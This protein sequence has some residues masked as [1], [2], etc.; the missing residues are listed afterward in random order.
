M[1]KVEC[2]IEVKSA[3]DKLW[4]GIKDS[5]IIFPKIFPKRLAGIEIVEGDGISTGSVRLLKYVEGTPL[6]THAKEKIELFDDENK[7]MEYSLIEG[8]L[9]MLYKSLKVCLQVVPKG[10]GSLVK[11]CM[12][13]EKASDAVPIEPEHVKE[14]ATRVYTGLDD[15]LLHAVDKVECEI[16]V[17]SPADKFWQGIKNSAVIYP[18]LFNR[19]LKTIEILEGD[20]IN[21]GSV[22]LLKYAEGTPLVSFAK[23]K[24]ELL[25]DEEKILI[26]S[27]IEGE[28]TNLYKTLKIRLQ[29]VPKDDGSLVKWSMEFEKASEDVPIQPHHIQETAAKAF[30]GMDAYLLEAY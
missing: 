6:V 5:A 17:K 2:E 12:E 15:Y 21:V 11:W 3:A 9:K 10:E 29:V 20:G 22:R 18:K 28:L 7:T 26:Y 4:R 8:E 25:D 24:V 14:H 13:F 19:R 30:S 16:E 23:E 27:V 1:G